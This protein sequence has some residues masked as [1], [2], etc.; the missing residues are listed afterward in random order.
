MAGLPPRASQSPPIGS[1]IAITSG[2]SCARLDDWAL[3]H[4]K[5]ST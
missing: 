2:W 5:I 3:V 4:S 1:Q